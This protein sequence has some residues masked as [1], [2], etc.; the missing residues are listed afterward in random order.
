MRL[1]L[2][3]SLSRT[4]DLEDFASSTVVDW[5]QAL[6]EHAWQQWEIRHAVL[7]GEAALVINQAGVPFVAPGYLDA[8]YHGQ[9]EA[10][11][12][13]PPA[14]PGPALYGLHVLDHIEAP[15]KFLAG[16]GRLLRP[17]GLLFLTFAY[18]NAEGQDAAAGAASRTR[19]YSADSLNKL[20]GEARRLGFSTFGGIDWTYHGNTV[21]DHTL[22]SLVLVK[23]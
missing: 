5:Q 12:D 10:L 11:A 17:G 6:A 3:L 15:V 9:L 7:R 23:R 13:D 22:A 2:S 14:G 20:I 4:C 19:I 18:W 16:A 8:R 21:D 1:G